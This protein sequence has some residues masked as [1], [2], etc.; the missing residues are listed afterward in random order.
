MEAGDLTFRLGPRG[1]AEETA[2]AIVEAVVPLIRTA[3]LE[4][5]AFLAASACLVPPD[6]GSPSADECAVADRAAAAI[7]ALAAGREADHG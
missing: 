7:R 3:A 5:A 2:R 4:E 6:G 1:G